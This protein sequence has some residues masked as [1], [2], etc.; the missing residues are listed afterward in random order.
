MLVC[1]CLRVADIRVR[2]SIH[3]TRHACTRAVFYLGIQVIKN[4]F[5][6][7]K[8]VSCPAPA[9]PFSGGNSMA[10]PSFAPPGQYTTKI[11]LLSTNNTQLACT[12]FTFNL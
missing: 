2:K 3:Q 8:I 7:C 10:V 9:G 11:Y 5:D 1:W 6:I 4:T 12:Q